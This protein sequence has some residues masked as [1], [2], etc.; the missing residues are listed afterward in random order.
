VPGTSIW[1]SVDAHSV[2]VAALRTK[3]LRQYSRLAFDVYACRRWVRQCF[4]VFHIR[5]NGEGE[6]ACSP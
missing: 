5:A 2:A 1:V 4:R 3:G 6:V